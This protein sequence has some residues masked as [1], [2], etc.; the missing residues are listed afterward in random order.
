MRYAV[1]FEKSAASFGAYVPDLPGC[2]AVGE[3]LAEAKSLI[4]EAMKQHL[5][6]LK[7]SGQHP[8]EPASVCA[9]IDA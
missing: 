3:S 5:D 7:A 2:V 8:P 6:E 1:V 9:Y 4:S